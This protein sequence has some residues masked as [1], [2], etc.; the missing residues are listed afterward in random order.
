MIMTYPP[1]CNCVELYLFLDGGNCFAVFDI[2]GDCGGGHVLVLEEEFR[3]WILDVSLDSSLQGSC[4]ILDVE[5][6]VGNKL[7]GG[8]GDDEFVAE[9]VHSVVEHLELDVDNLEDVVLVEAREGD[10]VVDTV[11]ELG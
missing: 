1:W 9:F 7:L 3:H 2:D 10:D 8:I 5:T 6:C 11:K 4:T